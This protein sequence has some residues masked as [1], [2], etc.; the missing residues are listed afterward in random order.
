MIKFESWKRKLKICISKFK[1]YEGEGEKRRQEEKC[2]RFQLNSRQSSKIA[3]IDKSLNFFCFYEE[4]YTAL[5]EK[6]L[7]SSVRFLKNRFKS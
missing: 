3:F 4:K 2:A 6:N 5:K 7:I 1:R